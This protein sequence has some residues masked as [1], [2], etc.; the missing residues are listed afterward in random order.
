MN[1]S[2][3]SSAYHNTRLLQN[4]PSVS[5]S[6][7]LIRNYSIASVVLSHALSYIFTDTYDPCD[8]KHNACFQSFN[9]ENSTFYT[10]AYKTRIL[11]CIGWQCGKIDILYAVDEMEGFYT[12]CI[13]GIGRMCGFLE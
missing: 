8:Y 3:H 5:L 1:C 12:L 10:E 9:L 11:S 6:S 4:F 7:L 13:L 2:L